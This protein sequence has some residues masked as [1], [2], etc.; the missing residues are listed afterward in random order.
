MGVPLPGGNTPGALHSTKRN[1]NI[2]VSDLAKVST[3]KRGY[4]SHGSPLFQRFRGK[5]LNIAS[6]NWE[7]WLIKNVIKNMLRPSQVRMV[8]ALRMSRYAPPPP[9]QRPRCR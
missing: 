9:K 6:S 5:P 8:I 7:V 1:T 4:L 2:P 3:K